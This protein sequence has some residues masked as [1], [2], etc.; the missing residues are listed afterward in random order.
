MNAQW[1]EARYQTLFKAWQKEMH[2]R[3][4][5]DSAQRAIEDKESGPEHRKAAKNALEQWHQRQG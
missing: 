4:G 3:T 2:K 1:N 5:R